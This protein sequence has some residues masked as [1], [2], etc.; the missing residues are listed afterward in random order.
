MNDDQDLRAAEAVDEGH[1]PYEAHDDVDLE[2]HAE[3]GGHGNMAPTMSRQG[4]A[5]MAITPRCSATSSG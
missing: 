2:R 1:L 5:A 3:H 4:T